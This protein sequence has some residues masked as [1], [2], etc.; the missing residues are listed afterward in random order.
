MAVVAAAKAR[1]L[2]ALLAALLWAAAVNPTPARTQTPAPAQTPASAPGESLTIHLITVG[3]GD[4]VEEIFGHNALLVRDTAT[5]YEAAFNYGLFN[6]GAEGFLFNFFQGRM[7]YRVA[8]LALDRTVAQYRAANRRVWAQELDLAP[9]DRARLLD[10]LLTATRPE[11]AEYRYQYFID[12]CSTRIRDVIDEVL[13]GQLRAATDSVSGGL[14]WRDDTRRLAAAQ[15]HLYLGIDLLLGPRGD[16]VITRWQEMWVPMKLRDTLA[17][18]TVTGSDGVTRQLVRSEELWVDSDR[19]VEPARSRSMELLFFFSGCLVAVLFLM[20]AY[21][22]AA[23][24]RRARAVAIAVSCLWG[25]LCLVVGAVLIVMHWTDHDFMYWNRNVLVFSPLGIVVAAALVRAV[26]KESS[27]RRDRR[28]GLA[29]LGLAI[30]ALVLY[31]LPWGS[32]EN[33]LMILVAM[34]MH[35][36]ACWVLSGVYEL[37]IDAAYG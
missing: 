26:R 24:S 12:N 16:E 35:A 4:R 27:R 15:L 2:P 1:R 18:L 9:A 14:T 10:L 17:S 6:P 3:P 19:D 25:L 29:A 28:V 20:A 32:Q 36:A 33:L 8:P 34:P 30:L 21:R 31:L 23:G 37:D 22:A 13:N 5:G 11:N 7:M